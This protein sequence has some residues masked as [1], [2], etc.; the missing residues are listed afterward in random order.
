MAGMF[1]LDIRIVTEGLGKCAK[2]QIR[3]R[4][5]EKVKEKVS[6]VSAWSGDGETLKLFMN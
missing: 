6:D 5:K 2:D 4:Q 1:L 3:E